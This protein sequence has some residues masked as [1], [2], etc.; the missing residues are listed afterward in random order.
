MESDERFMLVLFLLGVGY[1]LN[2]VFDVVRS[3]FHGWGS[4]LDRRFGDRRRCCFGCFDRR[5]SGLDDHWRFYRSGF[6]SDHG[7]SRGSCGSQFGLLL[8]TLGFTLATTHFARIVWCATV[9]GQ[10]AGRSGLDHWSG[11]FGNHRGDNRSRLFSLG[12]LLSNHWLLDSYRLGCRHW[13]FLSRLAGLFCSHW[14]W[15]YR[16]CHRLLG[17]HWLCFH[18][19]GRFGGNFNLGGFC[20]NRSRFG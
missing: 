3:L 16:F 4:L 14:R 13:S 19:H 6:G 8:Q 7:F 2:G 17:N 18:N 1:V 20:N 5:W 12:W 15:G 10:G 9:A 11:C